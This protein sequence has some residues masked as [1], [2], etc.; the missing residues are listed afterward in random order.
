MSP[1][2]TLSVDT[3][4]LCVRASSVGAGCLELALTGTAETPAVDVLKTLV[5][6]LQEHAQHTKL[7]EVVVNLRQLEFMNSACFKTFVTWLGE[8]REA[9]GGAQ[10]RIHFVSD[11][12]KH[13]QRRSLGALQCFAPSLVT[14]SE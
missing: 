12:N 1:L 8:L 9:H 4:D 11:R 10:Y 6:R 2:E 13:W 3:K 14:T 7:S 5:R